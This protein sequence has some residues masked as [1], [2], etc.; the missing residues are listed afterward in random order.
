MSEA[1]PTEPDADFSYSDWDL[2]GKALEHYATCAN[3]T[4]G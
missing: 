1:P 3:D 4:A 2:I